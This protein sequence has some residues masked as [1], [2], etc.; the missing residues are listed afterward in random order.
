MAVND[1]ISYALCSFQ[2]EYIIVAEKRIPELQVRVGVENTIKPLM[3]FSG[4]QLSDITIDHPLIPQLEVPVVIYNAV[5]STFGTGI[6]A[7]SPGHELESLKIASV[8]FNCV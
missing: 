7:I 6:N 3:I 5:K 2:D 1:K 8:R 4:E